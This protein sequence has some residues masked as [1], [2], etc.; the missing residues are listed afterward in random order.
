MT[1]IELMIAVAILGVAA[2]GFT[3]WQSTTLRRRA[4]D[5][6]VSERVLQCLELDAAAIARG[7]VPDPAE[8]A[9]LLAEVPGGSI[10]DRPVGEG[11]VA[12]TVYWHAQKGPAERT[13]VVFRGK[14]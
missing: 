10:E 7:E 5:E 1:L 2:T 8:R 14:R 12:I 6:V 4:M 13:L 11:L 3:S 9:L